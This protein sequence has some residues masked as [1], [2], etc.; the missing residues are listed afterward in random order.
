M[1]KNCPSRP[2][3]AAIAQSNA[4]KKEETFVGVMQILGA[5]VAME[6]VSQRDPERNKLEYVKMKFG[7][8]IVLTMVD[9]GETPKFMRE[10]TARR[11]GLKF[12]PV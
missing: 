1:V 4:K 5:V 2:K 11:I 7:S 6:V 9:S 8:G 3:V 12:V 10:D